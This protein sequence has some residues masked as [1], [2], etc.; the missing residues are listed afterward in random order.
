MDFS[1]FAHKV[2]FCT[3]IDEGELL[4]A[5]AKDGLLVL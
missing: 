3:F 5:M 4:A 1:I 2:G